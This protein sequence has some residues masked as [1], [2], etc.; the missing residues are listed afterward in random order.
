[1]D[2]NSIIK[3]N[4][5]VNVSICLAVASV[6]LG[7]CNLYELRHEV[8]SFFNDDE[9]KTIAYYDENGGCTYYENGESC[10]YSNGNSSYS[11]SSSSSS[12]SN[13]GSG[14]YSSSSSTSYSS[15]NGSSSYSSSSSS[16]Y[17]SSSNYTDSNNHNN[18]DDYY[19]D[20]YYDPNNCS[21]SDDYYNNSNNNSNFGNYGSSGNIG[22]IAAN[23]I[24]AANQ[25]YYNAGQSNNHASNSSP[26][27]SNSTNSSPTNNNYD[28]DEFIIEDS[29]DSGIVSYSSNTL[30]DQ[31]INDILTIHNTE[32]SSV[33][34]KK[35]TWNSSLSQIAERYANVLAKSCDFTHSNSSYGENLWMGTEG[36]YTIADGVTLW[37]NEKKDYN[38]GSRINNSNIQSIGHYTQMVWYN[39]KYIGCGKSSGCGNTFLVCNYDP[40]G[41]MIGEKPY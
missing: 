14:S 4:K 31:E 6:M 25:N 15:S 18:S 7:G 32:R 41:N 10:V 8:Y 13:N 22:S 26:T 34:V 39:T 29:G 27:N 28:N 21:N 2:I 9:E 5:L 35:L 37:L 12:S 11:Y 24:S 16:I 33:G 30:S 23:V 36:A 38:P 3:I 1:M 20:D 17:S 19:Y 40:M